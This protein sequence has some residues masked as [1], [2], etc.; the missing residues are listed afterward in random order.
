[1]SGDPSRFLN[2]EVLTI[3]LAN[4]EIGQAFTGGRSGLRHCGKAW[5]GALCPSGVIGP[6]HSHA[7]ER[8]FSTLSEGLDDSRGNDSIGAENFNDVRMG[9][10]QLL[11]GCP[12]FRS[13]KGCPPRRRRLQPE[14][15]S[16]RDSQRRSSKA[17]KTAAVMPMRV[18]MTR[19]RVSSNP[20]SMSPRDAKINSIGV[21]VNACMR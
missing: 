2:C 20:R 19:S 11:H 16:R 7:P 4:H 17:S 3:Q 12:H 9:L 18:K 21:N 10:K 1:M 8:G 6:H 5:M 15:A 13:G 14:T